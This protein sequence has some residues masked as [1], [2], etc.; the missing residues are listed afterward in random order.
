MVTFIEMS[1]HCA[2]KCVWLCGK[3]LIVLQF[4]TQALLNMLISFLLKANHLCVLCL[5]LTS[6]AVVLD[7][8][9]PHS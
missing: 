3:L 2:L 5:S 7:C 4:G 6:L 8:N 1:C 9:A